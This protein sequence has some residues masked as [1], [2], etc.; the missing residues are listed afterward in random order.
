VP[1]ATESTDPDVEVLAQT[2]AGHQQRRALP[3]TALNHRHRRPAT[4]SESRDWAYPRYRSIAARNL[5]MSS[6][7]RVPDT[8]V[9]QP[10]VRV[11]DDDTEADDLLPW[12]IRHRGPDL[13][14]KF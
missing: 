4:G 13:L 6:P 3:R 8:A 5:G 10:V 1:S 9:I 12:E 11:V 7:Q 2:K 14:R